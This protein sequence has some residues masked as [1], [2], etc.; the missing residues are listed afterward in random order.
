MDGRDSVIRS[1][2]VTERL[3][4]ADAS[5]RVDLVGQSVDRSCAEFAGS[6]GFA[7]LGLGVGQ[8]GEPQCAFAG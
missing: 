3:D 8:E 7:V 1:E 5:G 2:V 4:V 6:L